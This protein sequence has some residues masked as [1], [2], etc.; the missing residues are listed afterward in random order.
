MKKSLKSTTT[1][2][3]LKSFWCTWFI[4]QLLKVC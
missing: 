1:K 2:T 4:E 3:H